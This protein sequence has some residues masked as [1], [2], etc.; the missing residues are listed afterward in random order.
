MRVWCF[1]SSVKSAGACQT[2]QLIDRLSSAAQMWASSTVQ[3]SLGI[4]SG[5]AAGPDMW[6]HSLGPG[7][8]LRVNWGHFKHSRALKQHCTPMCA[9]LNHPLCLNNPPVGPLP[10]AQLG[11]HSQR[12]RG[13]C[14]AMEGPQGLAS[15]TRIWV[16]LKQRLQGRADL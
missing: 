4:L 5:L 15:R 2:L 9:R 14:G 16:L 1:S 10:A 8:C 6:G 12:C 11:A 3:G 7:L 13:A